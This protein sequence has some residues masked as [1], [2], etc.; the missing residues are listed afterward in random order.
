MAGHTLPLSCARDE[1]AVLFNIIDKEGAN[2]IIEESDD[3]VQ[4]H[5]FSG[6]SYMPTPCLSLLN[7]KKALLEKESGLKVFCVLILAKGSILDEEVI[8][9]EFQQK[10]I[11]LV[12][13]N[14]DM[15]S[16]LLTLEKYF[17]NTF[18]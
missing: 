8:Q 7:V 10:G 5:W 13:L 17:S 18:E 6:A 14:E 12:C 15:G 11:S 1:N 3:Y 16:S 2:W 9:D 4:S